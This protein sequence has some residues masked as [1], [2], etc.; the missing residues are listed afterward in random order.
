MV[1]GN[2]VA[3]VVGIVARGVSSPLA[4][5]TA[6]MSAAMWPLDRR[7][8]SRK[9]I[10]PKS[11]VDAPP[12]WISPRDSVLPRGKE[13]HQDSGHDEDQRQQ[14]PERGLLVLRAA[15][16]TTRLHGNRRPRHGSCAGGDHFRVALLFGVEAPFFR[17]SVVGFVTCSRRFA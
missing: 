14:P 16:S 12:A 17:I 6:D 1:R 4:I 7:I 13:D 11:R 10:R 5:T 15:A 3:A 2:N 9:R 8:R